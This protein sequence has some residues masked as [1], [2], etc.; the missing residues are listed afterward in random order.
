M[1]ETNQIKCRDWEKK[2]IHL[3]AKLIEWKMLYQE[4]TNY[5]NQE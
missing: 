2:N 3:Y 1:D 5:A 4:S